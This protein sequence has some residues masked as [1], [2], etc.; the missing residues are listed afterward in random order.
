MPT[1]D[2]RCSACDNVFERMRPINERHTAEC[3]CGGIAK[4]VILRAP[5][6]DPRMGVSLDFPT[7][8]ARWDK[9]QAKKGFGKRKEDSN[10]ERYGGEYE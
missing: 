9:K 3:M 8:A 2:Y 10:N 6:L 5:V 1:Y 4:L 7:M